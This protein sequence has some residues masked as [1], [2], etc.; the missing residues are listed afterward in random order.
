MNT[1]SEINNN[2]LDLDIDDLDDNERSSH[3]LS[4]PR[5]M[6]TKKNNLPQKI[7]RYIV[8]KLYKKDN[9]PVTLSDIINLDRPIRAGTEINN[10]CNAKCSFCGY[11]K[12]N[13][14]LDA[15]P[16]KKTKL[17]RNVYSHTLK[18]Y[19]D[20]GGGNFVLSPI[21]GEISS[22]PQWLDLIKEARF[23][24]NIT[25]V[26]CFSNAILFDRFG[27]ENILK[28]GLT[29]M[30]IS[31]SLG[32][33]EQ[34]KR[35]YGVDKYD[36]VLNNILDLLETNV[37]LGNPV[38][39]HLML[40]QDKPFEPFLNSSLYKK[41][42]KLVGKNK[43][44]I[45]DDAWDDFKGLIPQQNLPKGHKLITNSVS[46][47]LPCY[48]LY[49]KLV[50]LMDGTI[51]GCACRVEPELWTDNI[52]NHDTLNSAWKNNNLEKL[53]NNWLE[54]QII[55]KCCT[56]CTH[57][58]PLTNILHR[59]TPKHIAKKVISKLSKSFI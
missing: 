24:P 18:L 11:G 39:I 44:S 20:G 54:K 45:L 32:S 1:N 7:W 12:K 36:I 14:L 30:A 47:K 27:S 2:D 38:T 16:R 19:S 10:V 49:N 58:I 50:V 15:D 34:Y 40:R 56:T 48:A 25:G 29:N 22:D 8:R 31:T 53:R 57:Y 4:I 13:D 33:A 37:R 42:V 41:L 35:L 17:D 55:P 26:S 5:F 21:L 3:L 52:T 6:A 28:S 51:Q 23:Y 43:I 46:K 59:S 9:M